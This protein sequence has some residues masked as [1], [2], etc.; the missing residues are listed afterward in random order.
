MTPVTLVRTPPRPDDPLRAVGPI[1]SPWRRGANHLK[2]AVLLASL[3]ALLVW[4]GSA[5]WSGRAGTLIGLAL[6]LAAVGGSYWFSDRLALRFARARPLRPGELPAYQ[7]IVAELAASAG[8]P[9]PRLYVSPATQPNAFATGRNPHHAAICVTEGLLATL[10]TDEL[11]GVLA[12]ELA[13]VANRDIL[14]T[15]IAAALAT[16]IAAIADL[17]LWMPLFATDDDHPNPLGLLAAALLAPLAATLLQLA[18][19]RARE[20]DADD[21]GARL[22]GDGMPLA[23][24]L[25]KIDRAARQLP[26]AVDPAQASAYIINPL[27]GRQVAFAS[28]FSTH[29]PT[30]RRIA[31]LINR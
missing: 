11:K 23:R 17:L 21:T 8:L 22:I 28:L 25:H 26:I 6:G 15:S 1:T 20:Y 29:P 14:L 4:I 5:L 19:S 10:E 16:G 12:H 7:R 31:R 24:A 27:T 9:M 18:V 2:T 13:H 30:E 3:G